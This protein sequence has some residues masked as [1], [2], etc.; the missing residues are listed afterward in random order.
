MS[1]SKQLGPAASDGEAPRQSPEGTAALTQPLSQRPGSPD[2]NGGLC[3]PP[4]RK[5]DSEGHQSTI[6]RC[7]DNVA[8][9]SESKVEKPLE[10]F[11]RDSSST[12]DNSSIRPGDGEET[13]VSHMKRSRLSQR[14]RDSDRRSGQD[15]NLLFLRLPEQNVDDGMVKQEVQY[16][17]EF[18]SWTVVYNLYLEG[19]FQAFWAVRDILQLYGLTKNHPRCM[20]GL[21]RCA[22]AVQSCQCQDPT[23]ILA[24]LERHSLFPKAQICI[25]KNLPDL[26]SC[27]EKAAYVRAVMAA[28]VLFAGGVCDIQ[29]LVGCLQRLTS[30]RWRM[31]INE[32]L[33]CM[34]T[35]FY[36][37]RE[38]GV[39]ISNRFYY[40]V[41]YYLRIVENWPYKDS[42]PELLDCRTDLKPTREQQQ[43]L[44][45][46]FKKPGERVKIEAFAGTGKTYTLIQ[47]TK[48][49]P[50]LKFLYLPFNSSVREQA[51]QLFPENV[52]CE[53]FH[54]LA[55]EALEKFYGRELDCCLLTSY[56][57]S[58]LQSNCQEKPPFIAKMIVQTLAAFFA[59]ADG[60]ITVH[61]MPKWCKNNCEKYGFGAEELCQII[62]EEA[63]EI[64]REMQTLSP[65]GEMAHRITHEGYLKLWQ[66][67]KPSLSD[68]DVILVDEAQNCTPAM[69]DIVR[70]QKCSVILVGDPHQKI[71]FFRGANNTVFNIP[72]DHIF[73]L[74]QS[75]RFG[76]EIAYVGATILDVSKGVRKKTLVGN[77]QESDVSGVGVEGTVA[78]LSRTNKTVF[79]DAV[80]L[81]CGD[82]PAK[83][84]LLGGLEAFDKI[85]DIWAL[86]HP[87]EKLEIQDP[88]IKSW[89]KKGF[90]SFKNHAKETEDEELKSKIAIVEETQGSIPDL[91]D[92]ISQ[93]HVSS[94]E[95][96]D[97]ILGTVH[98]AKGLEFNTVQIGG[99]FE[100]IQLAMGCYPEKVP[101]IEATTLDIEWNLLYVA[102]TRAKKRLI[103]PRLFASV[104]EKAK[105][106]CIRFELANKVRETTSLWCLEDGCCN[107]IPA[108]SFLIPKRMKFAYSDGSETSEILLCP[109]CAAWILGPVAH[110]AGSPTMVQEAA[111]APEVIE[112]PPEF[113][114][115]LEDL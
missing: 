91:L 112:I 12:S 37:M 5:K 45:H 41:F 87:E 52:T 6:S 11:V 67:Q 42:N 78:H 111:R 66:L 82:T 15:V 40:N 22:A 27:K 1:S 44:N 86:R 26:E 114:H 63:K 70:S 110:L 72:H 53:T 54:S 104:L 92:K 100:N 17:K 2:S 25:A 109:S 49:W 85:R 101:G 84:H 21:I 8:E 32:M 43:I 62:V 80:K 77:K 60:S 14:P 18:I 106:Y 83:I 89:E 24:C 75:F 74:T 47:Y 107:A 39:E 99:D 34:A 36:A 55:K 29:K 96:A 73:Y 9:S 30:H 59:S 16:I 51:K 61:H 68:Y 4:E 76:S 35:L 7:S 38:N 33:Y 115:L 88:F 90:K 64:W 23:A 50:E 56:V 57:V 81:T 48:K 19:S 103:L 10:N 28:I 65:T 69:A 20:P 79:E 3:P 94:P 95:D 31:D 58:F 93:H 113:R 98:K 46:A 105:E 97:H 13:S 102:V 71:Y 108:D